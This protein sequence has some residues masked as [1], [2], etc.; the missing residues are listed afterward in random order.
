[1]ASPN[2]LSGDGGVGVAMGWGIGIML[3]LIMVAVVILLFAAGIASGRSA[4]AATSC[5]RVL[6]TQAACDIDPVNAPVANF[7]H[8]PDMAGVQTLNDVN[9]ELAV[10]VVVAD[11][12]DA[13]RMNLPRLKR[14][15]AN[16]VCELANGWHT[17][18]DTGFYITPVDGHEWESDGSERTSPSTPDEIA[19]DRVTD[20]PW[21]AEASN[22]FTV[23]GFIAGGSWTAYS[24]IGTEYFV[25]DNEDDRTTVSEIGANHRDTRA[26]V[27]VI[28]PTPLPTATPTALPVP[29]YS[30][31]QPSEAVAPTLS[32]QTAPSTPEPTA[33]PTPEPTPEPTVIPTAL[34]T[35]IP[36]PVCVPQVS[37]DGS[38]TLGK[39][40]VS[41][42]QW[43]AGV[44][45]VIWKDDSCGNAHVQWQG[46]RDP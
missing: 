3:S 16:I 6:T 42:T 23:Q 2:N 31:P 1:M 11:G 30:P 5:P 4:D 32:P 7:D 36:L 28:T 18:A 40:Q 20:I 19:L 37:P 14:D 44:Y 9:G 38:V 27:P 33:E 8:D 25:V 10:A 12:Y 24:S 45:V 35:A 21:Y 46:V 29:T 43:T 34:P 22:F 26:E 17:C 41:L 13:W 15:Y 39:L